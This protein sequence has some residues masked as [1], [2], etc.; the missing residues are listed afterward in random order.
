MTTVYDSLYFGTSEPAAY[1]FAYMIVILRLFK[2]NIVMYMKQVCVIAQT[3]A[4]A[5]DS[6]VLQSLGVDPFRAFRVTGI[7]YRLQRQSK[8]VIMFYLIVCWL[9]LR[10][11][12]CTKNSHNKN[13]QKASLI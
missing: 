1:F 5:N 10:R 8:A 4:A 6:F 3:F 7:C 9:F 11:N 12:S 2:L 13:C